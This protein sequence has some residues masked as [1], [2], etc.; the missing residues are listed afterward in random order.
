[1]R[2]SSLLLGIRKGFSLRYLFV[3]DAVTRRGVRLRAV[4]V[5]RM[6]PKFASLPQKVW[7][8]VYFSGATC[9]PAILDGSAAAC[10]VS[11]PQ[12]NIRQHAVRVGKQLHHTGQDS[13]VAGSDTP[14]YPG[15]FAETKPSQIL[16]RVKKP[17]DSSPVYSSPL[18]ARRRSIVLSIQRESLTPG[19]GFLFSVRKYFF[20][21]SP[22][23]RL[24]CLRRPAPQ[25]WP[26]T[27]QSVLPPPQV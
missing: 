15:V 14:F 25:L 1:M 8:G 16:G 27:P 9:A 18:F 4:R 12:C 20:A 26:P 23:R 2:R 10:I 22:G 5:T 24:V 21:G 13:T 19:R 6:R 17:C 11:Y 3:L 7:C